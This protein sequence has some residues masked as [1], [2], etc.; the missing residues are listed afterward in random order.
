M[1]NLTTFIYKTLVIFSIFFYQIHQY[2]IDFNLICSSLMVAFL[3][4]LREQCR[5]LGQDHKNILLLQKIKMS[6]IPFLTR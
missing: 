1:Q 2:G 3:M 6:K 5:G 4:L